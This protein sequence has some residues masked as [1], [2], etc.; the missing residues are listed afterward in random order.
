LDDIPTFR[1]LPPVYYYLARTQEGL[2][3]PAAADSYKMFLALRKTDDTLALDAK[4][5]L[6]SR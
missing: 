1:Y 5:R 4:R 3:S 2:H 6:T